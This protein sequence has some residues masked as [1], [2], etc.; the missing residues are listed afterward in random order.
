MTLSLT[1]PSFSHQGMIP[2]HH[3][4]D[5]EDSSPELVWTGVPESTKSLVL[6][7]DD[8]DAPDPQAPKMTWVH[9]ILYNIPATTNKLPAQV[10]SAGLPADT[11][12][13]INDWGRIGYGGPCPPIG[14]HRYFHKLYALNTMLPDLNRPTKAILEQAMQSHIIAQAELIGWY[15]RPSNA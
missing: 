7:I 14:T 11:L 1:S 2:A 6:I 12:E 4:C 15:C 13:G 9:W 5:G 8:P 10:P 3:T